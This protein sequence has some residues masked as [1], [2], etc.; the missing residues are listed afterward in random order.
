MR[1]NP[2]AEI[3][4]LSRQIR[5]HD[6]KYFVEATPEISD[7]EYDRLIA[8]LKALEAEHPELVRPT[9]RRSGLANS[10]FWD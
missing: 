4:D 5:H 7:L 2:A 1:A 9:A 6:T 8:R 10:R 3:A